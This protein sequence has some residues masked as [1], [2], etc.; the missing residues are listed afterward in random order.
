M[1]LI[2]T[3]FS[4]KR[5][6]IHVSKIFHKFYLLF[7]V[8]NTIK[9][10]PVPLDISI[11]TE[12]TIKQFYVVNLTKT[13]LGNYLGNFSLSLGNFFTKTS[14][15]PGFIIY[16]LLYIE[17]YIPLGVDPIYRVTMSLAVYVA[18]RSKLSSAATR[19]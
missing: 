5:G 15:H 3:K 12:N 7:S 13:G 14:G 16:L 18:G 10:C 17:G 9:E 2:R 11:Q 19:R 4:F 6:F 8:K 1:T